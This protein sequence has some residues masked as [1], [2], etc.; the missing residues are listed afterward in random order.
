MKRA[1]TSE[2]SGQLS[3]FEDDSAREAPTGRDIVVFDLETQRS[4]RDVGGRT[5]MRDLG[6]SVGVVY[7]FR[8]D[9]FRGYLE[10]EA[11]A[12]VER[13]RA[14]ELVVGF[15]LLGFDYEVLKGYADI[16]FDA[17]P[18]LDIMFDLQDRLGFRPKLDSVVQA[19]LGVGKTADG[20]QALVWW[21]EGRLD[22]I[23]KYCAD[24][25]RLTRDLYLYGK[26]NR[27]VLVSRHSGGPI[28]VEVTW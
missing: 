10:A 11:K 16:A 23:E 5:A 25:V 24:D 7:S 21:K 12:L 15:S 1:G 27:H 17:V 8:D 20:L 6:M 13:L 26:R 4:F 18:T 14:A 28:K 3:L 22:L 19:T 2:W 9:A